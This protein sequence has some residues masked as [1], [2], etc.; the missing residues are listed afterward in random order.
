M[1]GDAVKERGIIF[2][3]PMVR[4]LLVGTKTQTRRVVRE[5]GGNRGGPVGDHVKWFE[6]GQEDATRWCGHDG[7]GSLGWVRCPY[8]EP[9]DRLWVKETFAIAP[10]ENQIVAYRADGRCGAIFDGDGDRFLLH[11][12]WVLDAAD[13]D[14]EGKWYGLGK[15][16]GRWRPSIFMPRWASRITLDVVSIR[17]E[18]LHAITEEDAKE[19]GVEPVENG[20]ERYRFGFRNAWHDINGGD[21]WNANPFVWVIEFKRVGDDAIRESML[22]AEAGR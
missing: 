19:E 8:G 5:C 20:D 21:S 17:V 9:G 3:A 15:F 4:A 6:R 14:R 16:G 2:S 22:V 11:H 13:K 1:R 18:R 12:G 10:G 7:L